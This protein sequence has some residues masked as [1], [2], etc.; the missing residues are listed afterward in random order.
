MVKVVGLDFGADFGVEL[1]ATS[2]SISVPIS[3]SNLTLTIINILECL[4]AN[5][6]QMVRPV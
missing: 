4:R 2:A 5:A 6:R 1:A 3:A